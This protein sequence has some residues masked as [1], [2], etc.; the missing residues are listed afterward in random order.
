M[1]NCAGG[2]AFSAG[3]LLLS[4]NCDETKLPSE[5]ALARAIVRVPSDGVVQSVRLRSLLGNSFPVNNSFSS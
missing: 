1:L 5:S 3:E 4:R 2:F